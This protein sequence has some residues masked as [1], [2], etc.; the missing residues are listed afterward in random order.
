M[1]S[2]WF[3]EKC[4]SVQRLTDCVFITVVMIETRGCDVYNRNMAILFTIQNHE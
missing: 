1:Y 4:F 2:E 3:D